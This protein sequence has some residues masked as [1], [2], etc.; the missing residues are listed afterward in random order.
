MERRAIVTGCIFLLP[1]ALAC[2][3]P[4]ARPVPPV[5]QLS[6]APGTIVTSPDTL[7]GSLYAFDEDGLQ[8]L[9]LR[10]VSAD[11]RLEVDSTIPLA[12]FPEQTRS[13]RF[14]IPPGVPDNTRVTI[15]VT[16]LDFA[17]FQTTDSTIFATQLT[18]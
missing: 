7:D 4:R 11:G 15:V 6:F 9:T 5:V 14:F 3:D 12:G 10:A 8:T 13:M 17:G 1:I 2:T 16:V 18:P